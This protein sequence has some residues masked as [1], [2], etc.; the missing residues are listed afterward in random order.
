MKTLAIDTNV[1]LAYRLQREPHFQKAKRVFEECMAGKLTLFIPLVV[2]LETEWILRS[3]YAVPKAEILAFFEDLLM[4]DAIMI[5]KRSDFAI[6][7][8]VYRASSGSS[9]DDCLILQEIHDKKYD[10]LTFDR[11]LDK[12][13]RSL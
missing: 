9:L 7:L 10:F 8:Q 12:L 3:Q 2:C 6:T 13:Y 1:I 11:E 5:D 4:T